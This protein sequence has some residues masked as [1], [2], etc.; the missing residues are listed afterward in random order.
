MDFFMGIFW[1][2]HP[3]PQPVTRVIQLRKVP[4]FHQNLQPWNEPRS[5]GGGGRWNL[6]MGVS[7]NRGTPK[8]MVKAMEN[9]IK[10]DDLGVPLFSETPISHVPPLW[11]RIVLSQHIPWTGSMARLHRN[12]CMNG[13][14]LWNMLANTPYM[15]P[16]GIDGIVLFLSC[17]FI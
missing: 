2:Y 8:W 4:F 15:N 10:M 7:Q 6:D 3:L 12:T 9:P 13:G 1:N 5:L 16:K 14:F 17:W 11:F